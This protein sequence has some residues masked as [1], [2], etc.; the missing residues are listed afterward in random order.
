M[1]QYDPRKFK[2]K[3]AGTTWVNRD[4]KIIQADE[5]KNKGKIVKEKVGQDIAKV[6]GRQNVEKKI[7]STGSGI[8]RTLLKISNAFKTK[9][10]KGR[11]RRR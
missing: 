9:P 3:K 4:N 2:K 10:I 11:K 8:K 6:R 7:R 1:A 5:G